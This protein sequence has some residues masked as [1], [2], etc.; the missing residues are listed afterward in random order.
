MHSRKPIPSHHC[1]ERV[2]SRSCQSG[3]CIVGPVGYTAPES[4]QQK[5]RGTSEEALGDLGACPGLRLRVYNREWTGCGTG[6]PGQNLGS[7][8]ACTLS[9]GLQSLAPGQW[10]EAGLQVRLSFSWGGRG[11]EPQGHF[12]AG[13]MARQGRDPDEPRVEGGMNWTL[14]ASHSL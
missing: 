10:G 7:R 4:G 1:W 13:L 5:Q 6:V 12:R 11:K 2:A 14:S 8:G 3:L 9:A